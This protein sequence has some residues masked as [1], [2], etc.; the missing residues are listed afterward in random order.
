MKNLYEKLLADYEVLLNDIGIGYPLKESMVSPLFDLVQVIDCIR[1][2]R[3]S[4][5]EINKI[6]S[7]YE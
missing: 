7:K 6:I 5:K 1:F 2:K 3:L 4:R